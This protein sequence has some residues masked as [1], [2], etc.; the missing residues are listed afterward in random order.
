L[1]KRQRKNKLTRKFKFEDMCEDAPED[2]PESKTQS[3][4]SVLLRVK[5]FMAAMNAA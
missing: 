2:A 4:P 5:F 3:I 1:R